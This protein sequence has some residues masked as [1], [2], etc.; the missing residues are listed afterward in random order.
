MRT[1]P[2]GSKLS[3]VNMTFKMGDGAQKVVEIAMGWVFGR[4][5]ETVGKTFDLTP[6]FL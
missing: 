6:A 5:S 2:F 1:T 3:L 4:P